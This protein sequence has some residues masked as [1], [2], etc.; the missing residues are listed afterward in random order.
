MEPTD[1]FIDQDLS[2]HQKE[3]F[4]EIF[5]AGIPSIVK[6]GQTWLR[7]DFPG[8][9]VL[10]INDNILS[11]LKM[12]QKRDRRSISNNYCIFYNVSITYSNYIPIYS[13]VILLHFAV[14]LVHFVVIL[15]QF[16]VI[17]LQLVVIQNGFCGNT[18]I[19]SHPLAGEEK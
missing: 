15:L 16:I 14:I 18:R 8:C 4:Q 11:R 7:N 1:K 9:C 10:F 13:C 3:C 19:C 2:L 12:I 5:P 6:T 17:L